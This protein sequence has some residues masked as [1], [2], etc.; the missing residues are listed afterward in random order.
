MGDNV[1]SDPVKWAWEV[2]NAYFEQQTPQRF[3]SDLLLQRAACFVTLHQR[4]HSLRGCIGTLEPYKQDLFEEIEANAYGAAF[5][6]PRFKPL[7][8]EELDT[9]IIS[10]DILSPSEPV[11]SMDELDPKKYGIIVT[12]NGRRGVLLPDLEGVEN[13]MQQIS[14]ACNKGGF[15]PEARDIRIERFSVDRYY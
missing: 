14:I 15:T 7:K 3:K 4:D 13:V 10:V 11:L 2:L 8:R 6:D 1:F 12:S 9:L 5:R